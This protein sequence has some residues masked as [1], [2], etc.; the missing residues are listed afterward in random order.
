MEMMQNIN[1]TLSYSDCYVYGAGT[2]DYFY[3]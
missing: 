1:N 3:K 2:E